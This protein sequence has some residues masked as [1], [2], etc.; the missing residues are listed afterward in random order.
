[1]AYYVSKRDE[2]G[3]EVVLIAGAIEMTWGQI[4]AG[5]ACADHPN[6]QIFLPLEG[7]HP[8]GDAIQAKTVCRRCP[9]RVPCLG[10]ATSTRKRTMTDGIFGGRDRSDRR[11]IAGERRAQEHP[12]TVA[13]A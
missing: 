9:V 1:M 10:Y 8:L 5:A 12:A 13:E 6:P 7:P 3:R 4:C 2:I 11:K